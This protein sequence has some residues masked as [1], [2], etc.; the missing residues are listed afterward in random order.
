MRN[1]DTITATGYLEVIK[2]YPDGTQE[3]HWADK[4]TITSLID[5]DQFVPY[6]KSLIELLYD[7]RKKR[8]A[9]YK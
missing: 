9:H 5:N 1:K 8:G 4:N 2:L 6:H 3:V 7:L